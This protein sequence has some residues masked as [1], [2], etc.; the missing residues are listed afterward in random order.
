MSEL[1][2]SDKL[3]GETRVVIENEAW[4]L[5]D[6][7]LEVQKKTFANQMLL[8][9]SNDFFHLMVASLSSEDELGYNPNEKNASGNPKQENRP[10]FIDTNC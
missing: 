1:L 2:K 3:Q 8:K 7:A 4:A 6:I 5:R 9:D 10:V